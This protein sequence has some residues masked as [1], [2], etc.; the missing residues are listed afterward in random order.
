MFPALSPLEIRQTK[1]REIFLLFKRV[2]KMNETSNKNKGKVGKP[3]EEAIDV[4][5]M[6]GGIY[7]WY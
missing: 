5:G 4:T 1:A 6:T 3:K 7:D 2:E